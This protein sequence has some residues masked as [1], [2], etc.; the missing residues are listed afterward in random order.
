MTYDTKRRI[1]HTGV[2]EKVKLSRT[3]HFLLICLSSGNVAT[4]KEITKYLRIKQTSLNSLRMR[5]NRKTKNQLKIKS[6]RGVG[7]IL[8]SEIYFE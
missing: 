7:Y 3:E 1:L 2:K 5:L 6:I 4:Y 8:E